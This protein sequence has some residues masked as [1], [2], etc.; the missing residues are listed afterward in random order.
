M[1]LG[2][3]IQQSDILAFQI[4]ISKNIASIPHMGDVRLFDSGTIA[5]IGCCDSI[6]R[7]AGAFYI[8]SR[9]GT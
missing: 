8:F 9:R 4:I 1:V 3:E 6:I 7:G 2:K 5:L